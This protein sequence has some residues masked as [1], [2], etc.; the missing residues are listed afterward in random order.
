M[1]IRVIKAKCR[2]CDGTGLYSGICEAK[3]EAVICSTCQGTGCERITYT[4]FTKRRGM[5][6]I[7]RVRWS[8]GMLAMSGWGGQ[9]PWIYYHEFAAGKFPLAPKRES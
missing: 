1:G 6:G 7:K 5:R 4:P 9:G 2:S 8:R 3:G